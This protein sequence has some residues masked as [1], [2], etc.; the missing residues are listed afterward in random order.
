MTGAS[1]SGYAWNLRDSGGNIAGTQRDVVYGASSP[2]IRE[3][4]TLYVTGLTP[5]TSYTWKWGHGLS[6]GSGTCTFD[7]AT[8]VMVVTAA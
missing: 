7:Q 2:L 1:A 5:G 3:A 6:S 4:A 8:V